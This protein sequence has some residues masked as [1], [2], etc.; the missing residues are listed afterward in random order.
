MRNGEAV[1][2]NTKAWTA[3]ALLLVVIF[4]ILIRVPYLNV[5][6]ERDEGGYAYIAW[7]MEQGEIPYKDI[8]DNKPPGIYFLYFIILKFFGSTAKAIHLF[9]C[10]WVV[11]EVLLLYKLS[12]DLFNNKTIGLIAAAIFSLVISEPGVLGSAANTEIFML[13]PVLASYVVLLWPRVAGTRP[14][15]FICGLLQGI[16]FIFKPVSIFNWLGI[17]AYLFYKAKAEKQYPA[18]FMQVLGSLLGFFVVPLL[19][20]LYFWYHG[21]VADLVYWSFSYNMDYL[22]SGGARWSQEAFL[23]FWRR[24]GLILKSDLVF[25]LFCLY[26]LILLCREKAEAAVLVLTWLVLSFCGVTAGKRFFPHYFLQVMPPLSVAAAWGIWQASRIKRSLSYALAAV[27]IIWSLTANYKYLFSYSP[28]QISER[29]YTVNPFVE[30]KQVASF[31]AARTLPSETIAILGSEPEILFYA[32]RKSATRYIY[33]HHILWRKTPAA[34]LQ[35]QRAAVAEIENSDPR[36]LVAININASVGKNDDT[37][38]YLF[39]KMRR[40]IKDRYYLDGF[41]NMKRGVTR[42]VFGR[43]QIERSAGRPDAEQPQIMIYKRNSILYIDK[44]KL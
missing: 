5:P 6:L 20:L 43:E 28:D 7:R 39:E 30:A 41:V 40:I 2:S 32:Q 29:I 27:T 38:D 44:Q 26:A 4:T 37:P 17:L 19:S 12:A 24:F 22:S 8:Y 35:R 25:W 21:A 15:F 14:T 23:L 16:A 36:Y 10:W 18:F 11:L 9:M 13:L 33:F 3:G 1:L 42:Y 31:L 34:V